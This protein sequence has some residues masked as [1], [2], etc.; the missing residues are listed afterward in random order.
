MKDIVS[1]SKILNV[2]H[3]FLDVFLQS[4]SNSL[5][6]HYSFDH[7]IELKDSKNIPWDPIYTCSKTERIRLRDYVEEMLRTKKIRLLYDLLKP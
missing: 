4:I 2:Y 1:D 7:P 6:L 5:Y 3:K